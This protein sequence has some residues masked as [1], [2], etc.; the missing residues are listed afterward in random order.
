M[1]AQR[2]VT[3]R[4]ISLLRDFFFL[5]LLVLFVVEDPLLG[6]LDPLAEVVRL[7]AT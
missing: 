4:Q 3:A 6:V 7:A 2:L 5:L 1:T